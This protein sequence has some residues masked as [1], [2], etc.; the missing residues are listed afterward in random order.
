MKPEE[1]EA[2]A[3]LFAPDICANHHKGNEQSQAANLKV[4]KAAQRLTIIE[5]FKSGNWTCEE[6]EEM[7]GLTHQSCSARISELKRDLVII[8]DG[9]RRTRSGCLAAIYKLK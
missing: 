1:F 5:F 6:V 9:A 7:S 8:Q 3:E 2:A 4:R